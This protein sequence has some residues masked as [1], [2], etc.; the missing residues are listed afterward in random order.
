MLL[1]QHRKLKLIKRIYQ[2]GFEYYIWSKYLVVDIAIYNFIYPGTLSKDFKMG[3][4]VVEIAVE[5]PALID[6]KA[7]KKALKYII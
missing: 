5:D 7:V 6:V 2:H 3:F 1:Q 4:D